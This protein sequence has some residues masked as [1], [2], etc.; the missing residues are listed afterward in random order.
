[1]ICRFMHKLINVIRK[2][3]FLIASNITLYLIS[4]TECY[5]YKILQT[6]NY[7]IILC[8]GVYSVYKVNYVENFS[9]N[10]TQIATESSLSLS[11]NVLKDK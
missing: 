2:I 5:I 3:L 1:M 8:V 6:L 11:N 7:M 4:K 10:V 9:Q